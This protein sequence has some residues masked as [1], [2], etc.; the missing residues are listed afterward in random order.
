MELHIQA[1]NISNT[2]RIGIVNRAFDDTFPSKIKQ[3]QG[4]RWSP[5]YRC[6]H[7]PYTATSWTHFKQIFDNVLI[8]N[9][10]ASDRKSIPALSIP[11]YNTTQQDV[12]IQIIPPQYLTISDAITVSE[13]ASD[14]KLLEHS[15]TRHDARHPFRN[16]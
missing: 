9:H 13:H 11:E 4:S 2:T 14:K 6:W 15:S 3:I 5:V 8:I 16:P 1:L 10:Q 7:I 12:M